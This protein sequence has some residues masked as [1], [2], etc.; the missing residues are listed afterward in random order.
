MDGN[1]KRLRIVE[2]VRCRI[3]LRECKGDV[4]AVEVREQ[5][6]G[7]QIP[8]TQPI[9]SI[10]GEPIA[11]VVS[12][13]NGSNGSRGTVGLQ[14]DPQGSQPPPGEMTSGGDQ[15]GPLLEGPTNTGSPG[16]SGIETGST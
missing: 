5:S 12:Q 11:P 2:D 13:P 14:Q 15:I 4:S 6:R 10:F 7:S 9:G 3:K 1:L 8:N 16:S